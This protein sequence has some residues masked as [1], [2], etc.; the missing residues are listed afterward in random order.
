[1]RVTVVFRDGRRERLYPV[2][3]YAESHH[4]DEA[5]EHSEWVINGKGKSWRVPKREVRMITM[6][7]VHETGTAA[8]E[9][10]GA[11]REGM[12]NDA[13]RKDAEGT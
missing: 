4:T 3:S 2:L 7:Q 11:S 8:P 5:G 13:G 12:N 9:H 6:E 10:V 1:M